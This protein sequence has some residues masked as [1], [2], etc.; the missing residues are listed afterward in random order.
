MVITRKVEIKNNFEKFIIYC[1]ASL[2]IA[3]PFGVCIAL[4]NDWILENMIQLLCLQLIGFQV[5]VIVFAFDVN[6]WK[7]LIDK[8][9]D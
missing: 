6:D 9:Q 1:L 2:S 4:F 3:F 8:Y 5:V 7:S